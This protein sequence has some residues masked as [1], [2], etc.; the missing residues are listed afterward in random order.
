MIYERQGC[1]EN[2]EQDT[3][4]TSEKI[5]LDQ[6]TVISKR[7]SVK[8]VTTIADLMPENWVVKGSRLIPAEK[9]DFYSGFI[10][11]KVV[12][13]ENNY[14]NS[15]EPGNWYKFEINIFEGAD[16]AEAQK[17]FDKFISKTTNKDKYFINVTDVSR[18]KDL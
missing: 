5:T 16:E 9:M 17:I 15:S 2:K 4:K 3:E 6:E 12:R 7:D 14:I 13:I 10:E 18:K 1:S 11:V 8:Q